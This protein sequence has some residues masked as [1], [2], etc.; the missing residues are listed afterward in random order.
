MTTMHEE[1]AKLEER[2]STECYLSPPEHGLLAGIS[3][4]AFTRMHLEATRSK[5][6]RLEKL[7]AVRLSDEG[8][9]SMTRIFTHL[10][11][12][13]NNPGGSIGVANIAMAM[14]VVAY[15]TLDSSVAR[16]ELQAFVLGH[17]PLD[18][19]ANTLLSSCRS[20]MLM[21]FDPDADDPN[22]PC[23]GCTTA[24]ATAIK[25]HIAN[26]LDG[27]VLVTN[28]L[29]P[30]ANAVAEVNAFCNAKTKGK[31]PTIATEFDPTTKAII[32][33]AEYIEV[34]WA[35]VM[36]EDE[37]GDFHGVDGTIHHQ[38]FA[39]YHDQCLPVWVDSETNCT[40]VKV[41]TKPVPGEWNRSMIF[42]LPPQGDNG[43]YFECAKNLHADKFKM[44]DIGYFSLPV[45][46]VATN[47]LDGK[48]L[49]QTAGVNE[50]FFSLSAL[51]PFFHDPSGMG[52]V[53]VSKITHMSCIKWNRFGAKAAAATLVECVYRSIA[54][55][56]SFKFDRPFLA[57]LGFD[58]EDGTFVP[59]FFTEVTGKGVTTTL[60]SHYD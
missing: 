3:A 38:D 14:L 52:G 55:K 34:S 9:R 57:I 49:L 42:V 8:P 54:V 58:M 6:A 23:N 20:V 26:V 21:T 29:C 44:V 19:I 30:D 40:A 41:E 7:D 13:A 50:I 17:G 51:A 22:P 47:K 16:D 18:V 45:V 60:G 5:I 25:E 48:E 24:P 46:N 37:S 27:Q 53:V 33:A 43:K 31:I 1:V 4:E 35:T 15:M 56:P 32:L 39:C 2:M 28:R 59:E 11:Q 36:D 10:A 12:L